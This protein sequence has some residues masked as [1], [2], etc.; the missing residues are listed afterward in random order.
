MPQ[1]EIL[2]PMAYF[3]NIFCAAYLHFLKD[4][5]EATPL[6]ASLMILW[7]CQFTLV[8]LFLALIKKMTGTDQV[9]FTINKYQ[10]LTYYAIHIFSL[11][12]SYS[13]KRV[14]EMVKVYA[15]KSKKE[16]EIWNLVT[17]ANAL[18]PITFIALLMQ[19]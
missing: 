19:K 9:F 15:Q 5:D 13:K 4:R 14:E 10:F 18:L 12:K 11:H 2:L 17:I 7:L 16:K 8:M 6:F 1:G 3:G